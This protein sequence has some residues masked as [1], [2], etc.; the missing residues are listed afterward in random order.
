MPGPSQHLQ[1][2]QRMA[3]IDGKEKHDAFNSRMEE[4]QPSTTQGSA[5]NS[6][7][8]NKQRFQ[9]KKAATSLEQGKRQSNS[10]KNLHP[11]LQNPKDSAGFHGKCISDG[12][13]NDGIAQK[14]GRQTKISQKIS[15]ILDGIPSLYIAINDVKSHSYDKNPSICNNLK[16]N[17][18]SL[19]QINETLMCFENFLRTI[20]AS[21]NDNSFENKLSEQYVIIEELTDRYSEFNI[22]DIIET[23]IKKAMNIIK[24]DNNKVL[25]DIANSFTEVRTYTIALNMCFDTSQQEVSKLTMKLN[26]FTSDN[27]R[28]TGLWKESTHKE[29]MYKIQVSNLIQSFQH[30][31]RNSQRCCNSKMNYIQQLLHTLPRMSTPLNQTEG[32][33]ISNAQVLDVENS[34]SKIEFSTSFHNLE[35]S[36]G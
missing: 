12:Q 27:T 29:D 11:G 18:L 16:T 21:N 35:S 5:K 19:S 24:E 13:N 33:G 26:H 22:Y 15:D 20:R 23:R 30:E 14:G 4:K 1:V 7:S 17:N 10:H 6:P 3:P 25:D 28:Q 31:L 36:M 2:T 8:S 34:Q 9:R 32:S